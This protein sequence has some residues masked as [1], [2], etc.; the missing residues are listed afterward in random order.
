MLFGLKGVPRTFQRMMNQVFAGY[1]SDFVTVYLDDITIFSKC[2]EE[3]L[4]HIAL[5]LDLIR[6]A[7][8]SINAEKDGAGG[9]C[10]ALAW[11]C[12]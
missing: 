11:S 5:C 4:R 2:F 8:L 6:D 9:P 12:D 1:I 3:H 10:S 7:N